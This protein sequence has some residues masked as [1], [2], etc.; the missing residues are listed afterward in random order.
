[1]TNSKEVTN[2]EKLKVKDIITTTLL[3]LVNV[4]VF[5]VCSSI[6]GLP[7]L[8]AI[9]PVFVSLTQGIIFMVLGTKV[10]KKGAILIH[11]FILGVAGLNIMYLVG[12]VISGIITEL[13][14]YKH[15]GDLKRLSI[16]YVIMQVIASFTSTYYPYSI[17]FESTKEAIEKMGSGVE[18]YEEVS[19]M[20]NPGV[21]AIF[22]VF[23]AIAAVL[24]ALIGCAIMKKHLINGKEIVKDELGGEAFE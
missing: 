16:G 24:G 3:S 22:M 6:Y 2:S 9:F 14:I 5:Y 21:I 19:K 11:T 12:F 23:T 7:I 4:V 1:M 10:P 15:Y 13:L 18:I 20:L 8:I 17:A